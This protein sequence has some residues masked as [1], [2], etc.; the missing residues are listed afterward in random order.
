[1]TGSSFVLSVKM[2]HEG[3]MRR[4]EVAYSEITRRGTSAM[5]FGIVRLG[6]RTFVR[7]LTLLANRPIVVVV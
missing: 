2:V 5:M 1:M 6:K 4:S 3:V 7:F